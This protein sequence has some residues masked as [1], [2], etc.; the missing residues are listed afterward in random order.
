M[1]TD[2]PILMQIIL[3]VAAPDAT[4]NPVD[5]LCVKCPIVTLTA[6]D[7]GG[8][9]SGQGVTGNTFN[10][11]I[12]GVGDHLISYDIINPDCSD[13]DEIIITVVPI[14]VITINPVGTAYI[15]GPPITLNATPAGGILS[16]TGVTG[17]IFDPNAAGFGIHIMQYETKPDRWGCM[18]IDTIHIQ[19]RMPFT[20]VADFEPDTVGCS[21]LTVQFINKSLYGEHMSGTLGTVVY[22][23]EEN[24]SH[25]YY[26]PGN[27]IVKLIVYNITGQSIHNGTI[28]VYQNPAAIFNAYPTNV[29]NNEQIVVFYNY[30]Y[31]DSTYFWKFGDGETSTEENPYH[32]Y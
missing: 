3:T 5:T 30:S 1:R 13:S 11:A 10:P 9:W 28:S 21:P 29:V 32:K 20:P 6:H 26:V 25:T 12:A 24:P 18:A 23:T 7:L 2:A 17:N 19:V 4:I 31:Y 16:G 15:N 27:Y 14:P 22:S 8:I